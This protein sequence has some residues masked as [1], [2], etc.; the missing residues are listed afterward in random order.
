MA[1]SASALKRVRQTARRT[2][3]NTALKSRVKT[4]RKQ[5]LQKAESGEVEEAKAFFSKFSSA[6]DVATKKNIFHK[7][8]AANLKSKTNKALKAAVTS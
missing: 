2:E 5:T 8:K 3:R 7:N 6:V 1:N 4:L